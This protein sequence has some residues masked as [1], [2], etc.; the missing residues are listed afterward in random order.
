[1]RA[2][3]KATRISKQQEGLFSVHKGCTHSDVPCTFDTHT[4]LCQANTHS[5]ATRYVVVRHVLGVAPFIDTLGEV[6]PFI[7]TLSEVALFTGTVRFCGCT[8]V[9]SVTILK[10]HF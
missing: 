1:L 2:N 10:L 9:V 7:G 3:K 4:S 5:H 8:G 6:A